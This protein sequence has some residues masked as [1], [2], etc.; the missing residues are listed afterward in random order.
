MKDSRPTQSTTG[1]VS[2]RLIW[3]IANQR[4][5]PEGTCSK[6]ARGKDTKKM[7]QTTHFTRNKA[8]HFVEKEA[9]FPRKTNTP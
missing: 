8:T 4:E 1:P 6:K 9:R 5:A 2:R 7:S 3:K